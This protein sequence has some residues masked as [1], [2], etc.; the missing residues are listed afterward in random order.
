MNSLSGKRAQEFVRWLDLIKGLLPPK[1][2]LSEAQE[3]W[4]RRNK[5]REEIKNE[6]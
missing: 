4:E 3:I 2:R 5:E 1:M 6:S